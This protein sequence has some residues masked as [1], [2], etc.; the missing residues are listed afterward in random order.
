MR[1]DGRNRR[2]ITAPALVELRRYRQAAP[3]LNV[4]APKTAPESFLWDL[5]DLPALAA[6]LGDLRAAARDDGSPDAHF[7]LAEALRRLDHLDEA[8]ESYGRALAEPG[9]LAALTGVEERCQ[10]GFLVVGPPRTG[11]TLLRRVLDLHPDIAMPSGEPSFFSSRSGERSGSNR[12]RAPLSWYL[13][14]FRTLAERKPEAVILGEKSPHYF[15]TD[16]TTMAFA[17]LLFPN[18]KIVVTLRDPVER[19]WSEIK[20]QGRMDEAAVIAALNRGRYPNWFGELLDA[21]HYLNHLERWSRHFPREQMLL[22]DAE[23]LETEVAPQAK[24]LFE[25]LGRSPAPR[26]DVLDLQRTWNNR[27]PAF[28]RDDKTVELLRTVYAGEVW[29][30]ADLARILDGSSDR[31]VPVAARTPPRTRAARKAL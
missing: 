22:I 20:V 29:A 5:L 24:R 28:A 13:A 10:P 12:R 7:R 21:G 1:L 6:A 9:A 11:T 31:P 17:R 14:I 18:L 2:A 15:S 8:L 26:Q 16:D 23:V 3:L 4:L 25:W 19:A 30:A 27:T